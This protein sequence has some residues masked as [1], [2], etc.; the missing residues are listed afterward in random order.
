MT[1]SKKILGERLESGQYN[2]NTSE[3]L[4]RYAMVMDLCRDKVV[5]DIACGD[6][7]GSNLM[8][9]KAAKVI[10]VDISEE[11]VLSARDKYRRANLEYKVGSADKIPAPDNTIDV[12]I[13]FETLEHHDRHDEMMQEIKRVLVPGGLCIISTPDKLV[14]T[15]KPNK[16]NPFHVKELYKDEFKN[17][18]RHYF[19]NISFFKQQFLSGSLIVPDDKKETEMSTLKGDFEAIDFSG[20]FDAEYLIAFASDNGLPIQEGS[21]F[22]D[23]NF[24]SN[25]LKQFQES[26]L[27]YKLG[28][29]LLAP[30]KLFRGKK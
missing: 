25:K 12:L 13:S 8:A 21:L 4:H 18:I 7:Y 22:I 6:G 20:S 30:V 17:L 26:S 5:M 28:N 24:V 10:G 1:G 9:Q 14:Y 11:A 29:L 2:E 23:D 19:K 27:R 16:I 15:D 3:H